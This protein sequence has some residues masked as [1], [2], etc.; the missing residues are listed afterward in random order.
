MVMCPFWE[1]FRVYIP[2]AVS[3]RLGAYDSSGNFTGLIVFVAVSLLGTH[4]LFEQD[5]EK[6]ISF[7][8]RRAVDVPLMAETLRAVILGLLALT[9][10][11]RVGAGEL[12]SS[13]RITDESFSTAMGLLTGEGLVSK[14]G[15]GLTLSIHQR[16]GLA[17]KAIEA[18]AGFEAVSRSLGWLEFEEMAAHIFEENGFRA[19][20]RFRF[21]AMGRRWELDILAARAPYV[22][23]CEC[24]RW[25]RGMGNSTARGIIEAHLE[26]AEIF[27][28]LL[29]E[30]AG[31]AGILGW[32]RAVVVP[33]ALTLSAT[34]LDI[35]RRV[36]SVS[37]LALPSFLA[38]FDGQIERLASFR[39]ELPPPKPR[40]RQTVLRRR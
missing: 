28:G 34:P 9:R 29:P 21:S 39:V 20:R 26:K 36:P 35:Y 16:L 23:C 38:E 5:P 32:R 30:L 22:V 10:E 18:G 25:S 13:L 37:V 19:L 1:N 27:A 31:R 24:K 17:V 7:G 4:W 14:D 11:G 3:P 12:R 40:P 2:A 8:M 6:L 15:D 33:V